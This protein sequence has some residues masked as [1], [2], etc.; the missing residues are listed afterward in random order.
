MTLQDQYDA[1]RKQYMANEITHSEFYLWLANAIGITRHNLPVSIAKIKASTDEHLNDIPLKMW[2]NQDP[3]VRSKA[4][5]SGIRAWAL[6][7]TVCVLKS[8]AKHEA[9]KSE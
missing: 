2:D 3:I 1:K 4:G 5:L 6:S 7:D 8:F 9:S